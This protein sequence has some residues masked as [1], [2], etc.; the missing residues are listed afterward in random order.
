[1]TVDLPLDVQMIEDEAMGLGQWLTENP[2]ALEAHL[3]EWDSDA[4]I[5]QFSDTLG[6]T[7]LG[8]S[9]AHLS[10]GQ[11]RVVMDV[12]VQAMWLAHTAIRRAKREQEG[13]E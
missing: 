12:M 6:E 4:V 9:L 3:E 8:L 5:R 7:A 13:S 2:T 11:T 1:M 10:S